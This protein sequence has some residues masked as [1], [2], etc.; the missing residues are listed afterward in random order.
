MKKKWLFAVIIGVIVVC[1]FIIFYFFS[2]AVSRNSLFVDKTKNSF[3]AK[4]EVKRLA[5]EGVDRWLETQTTEDIEIYSYDNLKLH[6]KLL[7]AEGKTDN[8]IILVHGYRASWYKDFGLMLKFYHNLGLNILFPDNRASGESEGE[9]IGFGY[10]EHLDV[11]KWIDYVLSRFGDSS[12]IILHGVSMGASTVMLFTDEELPPQ[13]KGIIEDAGYTSAFE[14]FMHNLEEKN[15]IIKKPL[16]YTVDLLTR[17]IAG[18]SFYDCDTKNT[19]GKL[20]L[21]MLFIHGEKDTYVPVE[22]VYDNFSNSASK[23]KDILIVEGAG[24]AD[25]YYT[26]PELY[27][28]NVKNFIEKVLSE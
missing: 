28:K 27:E 6:S 16:I 18:Y 10:N 22:M 4:D 25:S 21:P 12:K 9:Y 11:K 17:L 1:S 8:T 7:L 13:V 3:L 14:Q 2:Y 23:D 24:H 20:T 19:L 15:I 26:N 5:Y